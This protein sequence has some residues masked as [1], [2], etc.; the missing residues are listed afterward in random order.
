VVAVTGGEG[1]E[2]GWLGAAGDVGCASSLAFGPERPEGSRHQDARIS[3]LETDRYTQRLLA[4][5]RVFAWSKKAGHLSSGN[6]VL[7]SPGR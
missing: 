6:G 5:F 4:L 7:A 3:L 2:G 1:G